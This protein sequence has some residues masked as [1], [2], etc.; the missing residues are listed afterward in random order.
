[1]DLWKIVLC[2]SRNAE[3]VFW[4]KLKFQEIWQGFSALVLRVNELIEETRESDR[5]P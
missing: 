2:F 5:K 4:D 3:F 1:M